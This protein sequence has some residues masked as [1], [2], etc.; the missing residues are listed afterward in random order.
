[1]SKKKIRD[2]EYTVFTFRLSEDTIKELRELKE[3]S[4]KSWNL[5]I[6]DLI[7]SYIK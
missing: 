2:V 7:K 5:F 6:L 4:G 1:M 3:R